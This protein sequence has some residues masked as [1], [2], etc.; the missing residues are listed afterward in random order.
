MLQ[1]SK[2]NDAWDIQTKEMFKKKNP[3]KI[4]SEEETMTCQSFN[5]ILTCEECLQKLKEKLNLTENIDN[6]DNV[7][8]FAQ[9]VA[10]H[11]V[12]P[13][14]ETFI[15]FNLIKERLTSFM[16]NNK[17]V[18]QL[19]LIVLIFIVAVLLIQSFRQPVSIPDLN[20]KIYIYPEELAKFRE[21]IRNA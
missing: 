18:K 3:H 15:N 13:V 17:D 16:S 7:E 8:T 6:T 19:I 12:Q 1:F 10:Q 11:D 14:K 20:N 21:I 9:P 2:I 5:H 4:Q